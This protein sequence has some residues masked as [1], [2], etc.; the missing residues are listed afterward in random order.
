MA[1]SRE[2]GWSFTTGEK[3]KNRVRVYDRGSRGIFLDVVVRDLVTGE[4]T[5]KRI[6]LGSIDRETA[7][8]HAEE[9]AATLRANGRLKECSLTLGQLFDSYESNVTPTKG[10]SGRKHDRRVLEMM[11]RYFGEHRRVEHLDRRDWDGF[12][13]DRKAGRTRPPGRSTSTPTKNRTVEQDLRLLLAVFNWALVVR[14]ANGTR[15]L[16]ENPFAGFTVPHEENPRRPILTHDEYEKLLAAAPSVNPAM[17]TLLVVANETGHRINSIRLLRWPDVSFDAGSIRWRGDHDKLGHEHVTPMT[18]A[19]RL[20][21]LRQQKWFSAG[22][23]SSSANREQ[24]VFPAPGDP[25]EPMSRHLARDYWQRTEAAAGIARVQGRGWHSL[26]RKFATELKGASLKDL[27]AL[28]GWKD[29]NTVLKCYQQPDPDAMRV[30]LEN[31][32]TLRSVG[33]S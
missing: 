12:I 2:A 10:E 33:R 8:R 4:A 3:G 24:W 20:A 19:A 27:C 13:R 5:R 26:R 17:E 31:R 11:R 29:H 30:A 6:S 15:V 18:D 7:K 28:G 22:E 21:F 16:T 32:G 1:T 9:L 23:G 14:D 25:G